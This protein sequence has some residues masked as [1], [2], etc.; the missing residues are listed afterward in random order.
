MGTLLEKPIQDTKETQSKNLDRID[1]TQGLIDQLGRQNIS[2][3]GDSRLTIKQDRQKYIFAIDGEDAFYVNGKKLLERLIGDFYEQQSSEETKILVETTN[4][5]LKILAGNDP[6]TQRLSEKQDNDFDKALDVDDFKRRLDTYKEFFEAQIDDVKW[7]AFWL[8]PKY[9]GKEKAWYKMT[10]QAAE[11]Q[12][13]KLRNIEKRVNSILKEGRFQHIENLDYES[14][15]TLLQ[16]SEE[17]D[18]IVSSIPDFV[19]FR[20]DIILGKVDTVPYFGTQIN[21]IADA[22]KFANILKNFNEQQLKLNKYAADA[23]TQQQYAQILQSL[24]SYF[25]NSINNPNNFQPYQFSAEQLLALNYFPTLKE[26]MGNIDPNNQEKENTD[27]RR[28]NTNTNNNTETPNNTNSPETTEQM[29]NYN[30]LG[31]A[32]SRGWINGMIDFGLNKTNMSDSQKETRKSI[33]NIWI[34]VGA[35]VV[36]WN[37]FKNAFKAFSSKWRKDLEENG[38]WKWI[39]GPAALMF[40]ANA[41]K[42]ESITTLL[43]WWALSK[44]I[45]DIFGGLFGKGKS[46]VNWVKSTIEGAAWAHKEK[47]DT[48]QVIGAYHLFNWFTCSQVADLL[49][50]DSSGKL[51]I[52]ADQYHLL[53]NTLKQDPTDPKKAAAAKYLE[54]IGEKDKNN[55]IDITLGWMGLSIEN[56]KDPSREGKTFNEV[57]VDKMVKVCALSHLMEKYDHI[58]PEYHHLIKEYIDKDNKTQKDLDELEARWYIFEK[59]GEFP[60]DEKRQAFKEKIEKFDLKDTD[61]ESLKNGLNSFRHLWPTDI[62]TK[63]KMDIIQEGGKIMLSTYGQKTK[64]DVQRKSIMW[65][66]NGQ[67]KE[68]RFN[69]TAELLKAANLINRIFDLVDDPSKKT[70]VSKDPFNI[71]LL[72]RDVE[73]DNTKFWSKVSDKYNHKDITIISGG[74]GW[75]LKEISPTLEENKGAFVWLLNQ[76]FN[77][78]NKLK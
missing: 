78:I 24:Q 57:T 39:I 31:D 77:T 2:D 5:K 14:R 59:S 54:Q 8:N 53:L 32:F 60:P 76:R 69:S 55:M 40:G 66:E 3:L 67:E 75:A 73:Y 61:K 38:G 37:F 19:S 4:L 21:S 25:E 45:W 63:N 13:K 17:L 46:A 16:F 58:N 10:K 11:Q 26:F 68:I 43:N 64:I 49:E 28:N 51:K 47:I 35:W 50:K 65:F 1:T 70:N 27:K 33:G 15:T 36:T 6:T 72:G 42:W 9:A 71:S 23:A 41:W 34:L 18:A 20:N 48:E 44:G 7:Q 74:I 56:L 52:K 30:N 22:Q 62:E 12:L 29:K